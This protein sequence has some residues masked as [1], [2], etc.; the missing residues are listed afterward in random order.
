MNA[1]NTCKL[2]S[3]VLPELGFEENLFIKLMQ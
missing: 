1:N 3:A 2:R